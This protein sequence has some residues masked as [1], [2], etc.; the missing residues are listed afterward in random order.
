MAED[1]QYTPP[2]L[3]DKTP[4]SCLW[5]NE[6][7]TNRSSRIPAGHWGEPDDIAG[8]VLFLASD[9]AHYV[10]GEVLTVDDGWMG[11]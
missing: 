9:A 8:A 6:P 2:G 10:H 11:R 5:R 7:G 3:N 4:S 1:C